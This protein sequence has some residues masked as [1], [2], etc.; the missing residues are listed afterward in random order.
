[1][2]KEK[3]IEI[4][5][6]T[7]FSV[8]IFAIF[9]TLIS[10]NGVVIGNDPAV[11]LEKAQIFINTGQI[12]LSI[13]SWT[14]PLYEIILAMFISVSGATDIGQLIFMVKALTVIVN[15]LMFMS[16]YLVGSKFF[17]KKVGAVAAVLLL[18][19]F[20]IFELNLW[21]GYTTV[22]GIA[23]LMLLL[24]YLPLSIEKFGYLAVMFFVGF[25]R[26]F[27]PSTC[28]FSRRLYFASDSNLFTH[29]SPRRLPQSLNRINFWRRHSILHLL[30]PSDDRLP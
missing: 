18:M 19:C 27:V 30:L 6:I 15:W 26:G 10:M 25:R 29:K 20:P 9:F 2:A 12:P 11:H 5:F 16:V 14:P 13:L 22:L 7:V 17:S 4:A 21:G 24:V 3:K 28:D 23:F 8:L 1:M